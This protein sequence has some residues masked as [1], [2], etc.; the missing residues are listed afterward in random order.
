[1][2]SAYLQADAV[3]ARIADSGPLADGLTRTE[4]EELKQLLIPSA[5]TIR[6]LGRRALARLDSARRRALADRLQPGNATVWEDPH[7]F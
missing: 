6:R 1:M 4:L 5:S 3:L 2:L 7:F